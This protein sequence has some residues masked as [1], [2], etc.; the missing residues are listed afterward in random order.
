[1]PEP[2]N[3]LQRASGD[4]TKAFSFSFSLVEKQFLLDDQ[5][6]GLDLGIG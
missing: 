3:Q 2:R 5:S 6:P 4:I 1:M